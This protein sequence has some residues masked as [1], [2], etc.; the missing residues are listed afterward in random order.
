MLSPSTQVEL[1]MA[2]FNNCENIAASYFGG[3]A[4]QVIPLLLWYSY[5]HQC[6]LWVKKMVI[7]VFP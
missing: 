3:Q 4:A 6:G 5:V 2:L 7:F 1:D